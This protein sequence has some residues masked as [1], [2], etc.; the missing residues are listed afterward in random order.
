MVQT[1][2][3][4]VLGF[5]PGEAKGQLRELV[6]FNEAHSLSFAFAQQ[7]PQRGSQGCFVPA[8]GLGHCRIGTGFVASLSG[9]TAA[10]ADAIC[11]YGAGVNGIS[12]VFNACSNRSTSM[13]E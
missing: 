7:L 2:I 13:P 6:P 11:P 10:R 5:P 8:G 12:S 9:G 4:R 1:K 3:F